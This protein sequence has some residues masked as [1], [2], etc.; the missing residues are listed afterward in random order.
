MAIQEALRLCF[1]KNRNDLR[2]RNDLKYV[3]NGKPQYKVSKNSK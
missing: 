1:Q 3:N 2:K